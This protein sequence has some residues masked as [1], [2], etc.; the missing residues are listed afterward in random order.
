M[1]ELDYHGSHS[2]LIGGKDTWSTFHLIP[3][4]EPYVVPPE[5]KTEYVD[6]PGADGQLDYTGILNGVKF[7]NRKGS[8][9]FYISPDYKFMTVYNALI[10]YMHGKVLACILRDEPKYY[11]YGRLTIG[12]PNI[13][14][15]GTPP[16][17][18]INY[19]FEPYK[20]PSGYIVLPS[21]DVLNTD[22]ST[23]DQGS[24]G[25]DGK[26]SLDTSGFT[27]GGSTAQ[28]TPGPIESDEWLW[29]DLFSNTITY[30]SFYVAG[31]KE[32]NLYNS[33]NGT[34]TPAFYCTSEMTVKF[35]DNTYTLPGTTTTSS[36]IVLQPGDNN[37]TFTGNGNVIV[38]Y[39]GTSRL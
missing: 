29:N 9:S 38:S 35:G 21:N 36:G 23:A 14:S 22:S 3:D 31:S 32:R 34:I 25:T 39:G 7:K 28:D 13:S 1:S 11:Y 26:G 10:S 5:P 16:K 15:D 8:W 37:M 27:G 30:G 20:Y 17:V 2:I 19:N 4:G 6:I 18:T 24:M 12:E 33:T